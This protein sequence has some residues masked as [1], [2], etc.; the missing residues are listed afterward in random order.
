GRSLMKRRTP[1]APSGLTGSAKAQS[2]DASMRADRRWHWGGAAI[3]AA[4]VWLTYQGGLA[5]PFI[6]DDTPSIVGNVTLRHP[7]PLVSFP[8]GRGSLQPPP[9]TAIYARPVV[10]LSFALNYSLTTLDPRGYRVTNI[11][12]HV[13]AAVTLAAIVRRTLRLDFFQGRFA[14]VAGPL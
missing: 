11:V 6:F 2:R 14:A 3:I 7:S 1:A 4:V 9:Q 5:A 12:L 8:G 13:L 10:N